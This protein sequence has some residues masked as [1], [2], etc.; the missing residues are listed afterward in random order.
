MGCEQWRGKLDSYVDGELDAAES[1]A[2]G[3]H[4]QECAACAAEA[5]RRVQMKRSVQMAGKRYA[6]SAEFRSRIARSVTAKPRRRASWY[7]KIL[8]V[9]T[10]AVIILSIAM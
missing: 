6:P 8:A 9:P 3:R 2:V 5:L 7:W 10:L 4:L 1:N